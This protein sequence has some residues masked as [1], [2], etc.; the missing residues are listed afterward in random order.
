MQLWSDHEGSAL[1]PGK[2][3]ALLSAIIGTL[4]GQL[5]APIARLSCKSSAEARQP[6]QQQLTSPT[7]VSRQALT[8]CCV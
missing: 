1:L 6:S 3:A 7:L 4:G 8:P 5:L 2:K